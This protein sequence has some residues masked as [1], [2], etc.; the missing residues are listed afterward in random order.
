MDGNA[1]YFKGRG[2][3]SM[4]LPQKIVSAQSHFV[5]AIAPIL[6]ASTPRKFLVEGWRGAGK[7]SISGSDFYRRLARY[8]NA[9]YMP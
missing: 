1:A 2:A 6:A 5:A 3:N 8:L 7:I 9:H 4:L